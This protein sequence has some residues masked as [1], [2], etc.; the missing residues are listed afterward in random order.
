MPATTCIGSVAYSLLETAATYVLCFFKVSAKP[1]SHKDQSG[2]KSKGAPSKDDDKGAKDD[3][4]AA[5][6]DDKASKDDDSIS[7]DGKQGK[8]TFLSVQ[9]QFLYQQ[10]FG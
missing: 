3:D 1:S 10:F 7:D 8:H 9:Q 2:D 5:K 4:K 6:D